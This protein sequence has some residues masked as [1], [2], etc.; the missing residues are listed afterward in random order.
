MVV[1]LCLAVVTTVAV[2]RGEI[3]VLAATLLQTVVVNGVGVEVVTEVM[4][5]TAVAVSVVVTVVVVNAVFVVYVVA[6]GGPKTS[7]Q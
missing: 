3:V 7:G 2:M 6:A 4:V 1:V 5:T